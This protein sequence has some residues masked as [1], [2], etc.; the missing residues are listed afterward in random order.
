[1][2]CFFI[3]IQF[4]LKLHQISSSYRNFNIYS[5]S[6]DNSI[7]F[8]GNATTDSPEAYLLN[9]LKNKGVV[10]IAQ[11]DHHSIALTQ[12]GEIFS[13]GSQ[14]GGALGIPTINYARDGM[15]GE[16]LKVEF[17]EEGEE[18]QIRKK[19]AF[20]IAAGGWH[21]AALVIDLDERPLKEEMVNE[22]N[23]NEKIN[24]NNEIS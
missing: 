16:P 13:W 3:K 23:S 11:G 12:S 17:E 18:G 24:D 5:Q 2:A 21:S 4:Y 9:G 1:M 8:S 22:S 14:R 10:D 7:V 19:F 20:S 6:T 15:I